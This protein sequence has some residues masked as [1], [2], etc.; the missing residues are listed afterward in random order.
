MTLYKTIALKKELNF[1]PQA[2]EFLMV[3]E[4]LINQNILSFIDRPNLSKEDSTTLLIVSPTCGI[5]HE[6]I[7]SLIKKQAYKSQSILFYADA[8]DLNE[9]NK[10]QAA[11]KDLT[12]N[13]LSLTQIKALNKGIFPYYIEVAPSGKILKAFIK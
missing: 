11:Y 12:I 4:E 8:V 2:N 6:K 10:F 9:F 5:C 1:L 13:P 7:E 3:Y